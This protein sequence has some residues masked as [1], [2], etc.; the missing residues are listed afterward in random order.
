VAVLG[1]RQ[2][3]LLSGLGFV[4]LALVVVNGVLVNQNR[5]SQRL[6]VQRQQFVQQTVALEALYRD[7]VKSLAELAVKNNDR[8][9]ID[10]LTAQGV[11]IT[12][13]TPPAPGIGK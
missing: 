8:Q 2:S 9:V 13:N 7:I 6:L 1:K 12:V 11:N 3:L 10:M 4:A 5:A